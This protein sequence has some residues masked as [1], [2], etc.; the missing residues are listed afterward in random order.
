M[1]LHVHAHVYAHA[2]V[3]VY[4]HAH[5]TTCVLFDKLAIAFCR[6]VKMLWSKSLQDL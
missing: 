1:E 6:N 2:H 4:A 3:H 5:T